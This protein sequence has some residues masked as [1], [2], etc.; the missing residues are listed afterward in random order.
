MEHGNITVL[1][2]LT[3]GSQGVL[4]REYVPT[5]TANKLY[6][7]GSVLYWNGL[8]VAN[9]YTLPKAT[10]VVLGGVKVGGGLLIDTDG[11][12]R[13][14]GDVV[15]SS[16][17]VDNAGSAEIL[18][19]DPG[20][21]SNRKTFGIT[22]S[23]GVLLFRTWD[24]AHTTPL[25]W[26]QLNRT[27][28][29][30]GAA[31]DFAFNV[32]VGFGSYVGIQSNVPSVTTDKLYNDSGVLKWNG[33]DISTP[34]QYNL[35]VATGLILGGV[36]AGTNVTIAGDG[37]LSAIQPIDTEEEF[38]VE[39]PSAMAYPLLHA[40]KENSV[41][42]FINGLK[43]RRNRNPGFTML[44]NSVL[45]G[46]ITPLHVGDVVEVHYTYQP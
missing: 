2:L 11:V 1:E 26:A 13:V 43:A 45:F 21:P 38:V 17:T 41:L 34:Y 14:G 3:T 32:P 24:D 37:T 27:S 36:K 6:R 10:S 46:N 28:G 25:V 16:M 44:G 15:A 42:V 30:F 18:L 12:I 31:T 39:D 19:S 35:P 4:V 20:A 23:N 40:P 29:Y 9:Q 33:V 7:Q 8:P 5:D 22:S